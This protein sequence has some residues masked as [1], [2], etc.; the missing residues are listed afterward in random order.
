MSHQVGP[1]ELLHERN[2][3]TTALAAAAERIYM[4]LGVID[5][6]V[7]QPMLIRQLQSL[8]CLLQ[9]DTAGRTLLNF[10]VR[11][12]VRIKTDLQRIVAPLVFCPAQTVC[13]RE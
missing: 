10:F 11:H 6:Q 12:I 9:T 3:M 7:D 1:P 4:L 8:C 5:G 13:Q 2:I